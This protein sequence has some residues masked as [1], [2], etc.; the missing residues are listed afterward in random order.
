M[1][2]EERKFIVRGGPAYNRFKLDNGSQIGAN[3]K[4]DLHDCREKN[5]DLEE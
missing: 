4:V 2:F 1:S 5:N 3:Q